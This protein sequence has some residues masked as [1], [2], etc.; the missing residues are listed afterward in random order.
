MRF[1]AHRTAVA[2]FAALIA[3]TFLVGGFVA[4]GGQARAANASVSLVNIA[5]VPAT[6]NIAVGD[7]VTWTNN[8]TSAIPHTVTSDTAGQFDSGLF[9]PGQTFSHTFTSAGTFTYHCNVH[10][11][12]LG[13]VIVA[14]AATA[15]PTTPS[16]ATATA[17]TPATS[18]ATTTTPTATATTP[19]PTAT[20]STP[21]ATATAPTQPANAPINLTLSGANEVPPVTTTATGNF[22]ATASTNSLAFTLTATGTGLTM[23]HIHQ[24]AAGTNGPI[25][26]FLFGPVAAG[27]NSINVSGT[28]T[29]ANLIGPLAGNMAG[30]MDALRAGNLYVNAHSLANPAGEIRAQIPAAVPA[31]A[32]P[33]TGSGSGSSGSNA[34]LFFALAGIAGAVAIAGGAAEVVRRRR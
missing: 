19:P 34:P 26:A 3:I 30:F 11:S 29:E 2:G 24:G 23:A 1:V 8:E 5:F 21:A 12:M 20:P 13:S 7:T 16:T 4:G 18:T 6:V 32:A 22:R 33:A 28:I 25:V 31:P 27:V 14:A 17:T 15:T 9:N 10:P